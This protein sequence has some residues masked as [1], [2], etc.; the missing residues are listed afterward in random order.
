[1]TLDA[2]DVETQGGIVNSLKKW[3]WKAWNAKLFLDELG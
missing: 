1:M 2:F 3:P